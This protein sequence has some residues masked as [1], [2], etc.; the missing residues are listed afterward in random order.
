MKLFEILMSPKFGDVPKLIG[1]W[2]G[3]EIWAPSNSV[4]DGKSP[5]RT[6]YG[7]Y[8]VY[9]RDKSPE[10]IRGRLLCSNSFRKAIKS[11]EIKL[12]P[13]DA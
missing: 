9:P 1:K 13:I 10:A 7:F 5:F 6:P 2:K 12:D 11:G 3:R 4:E 8:F